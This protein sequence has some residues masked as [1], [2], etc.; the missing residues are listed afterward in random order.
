ML[1]RAH[2][3]A[4]TSSGLMCAWHPVCATHTRRVH[5]G[6]A[7]PAGATPS[8]MQRPLLATLAVRQ[9]RERCTDQPRAIRRVLGGGVQQ[10]WATP[11]GLT[12]I[13][14][15]IIWHNADDLARLATTRPSGHAG[16]TSARALRSMVPPSRE[17]VPVL[18]SKVGSI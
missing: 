8:N 3:G 17:L 7:P 9:T 15:R 11:R 6:L 16:S 14:L 12:P 1:G 10:S 5:I 4:L 18:R 2:A 13:R